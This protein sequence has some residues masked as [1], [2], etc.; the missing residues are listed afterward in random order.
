MNLIDER[1]T[2]RKACVASLD[3][4]L[5]HIFAQLPKIK[6]ACRVAV[7]KFDCNSHEFRI[8]LQISQSSIQHAVFSINEAAILFFIFFFYFFAYFL[9]GQ[10]CCVEEM[11][12]RIS[13]CIPRKWRDSRTRVSC[14]LWASHWP[15]PATICTPECVFFSFNYRCNN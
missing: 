5:S 13:R 8:F 2:H 3:R 11:A 1:F 14:S 7:L 9:A 10:E 6:E 4:F 12:T 15:F